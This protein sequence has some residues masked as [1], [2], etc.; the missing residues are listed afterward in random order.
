METRVHAFVD[1][2]LG[3]DDATGVA[4]RIRSGEISAAEAIEA[5]IA[6][7][8]R[9]E[10][11]LGAVQRDDF[12]RARAAS[13]RREGGALAGVFGG[14]PAA[15]KD[16]LTTRGRGMTLGSDAVSDHPRSID[17]D[18]AKQLY[19]TGMIPVATSTMPPFGWTASTERPG[20]RVTRNPW[21]LERSAG[22]S[23]G[24]SA[25]LVAAGA[26]PIAHGNDG[27][28]SIRIPAAA[29]GLVGLKP[30]RGR[31]LGDPR[32]DG[33][34]VAIV[35]GGVLT[36]SVRDTAA[37]HAALEE[38]YRNPKLQP[39]GEV[40]GAGARRLR[41][42]V[43]IDSPLG[44]PSDGPTRAALEASADL[45]D[46]LGHQVE[47]HD[48]PTPRSF[49]TDFEDYWAFLAFMVH[50]TG[51]KRMGEGFDASR[52]DPLTLGLS[53]QAARR[54]HRMPLAIARL[55]ASG[56]AYERS[57][58][59]LDVVMS[60]VVAHTTP[61]IGYLGADLP[62]E[63]HL[64]RLRAYACFTPLHN[65]AGAPAI[66]LPLGE[67]PEGMPIGVMFAARRGA[68]RILLELAYELEAAAPF[69]R[70]DP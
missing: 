50:R 14:V 31:H 16:N 6:R 54:L 23:S 5:A 58:G 67:S 40:K 56:R 42:G 12:E 68:E 48:S 37:L 43:V 66:S 61:Q 8:E 27:G 32:T 7:I 55:R 1:D 52:L 49:K 9:V 34:P 22:G 39:I 18:Y 24:G 64:E 59:A 13:K 41:V 10:P 36:R 28:G 38:T 11:Q 35:S 4:E 20:D 47:P 19:A 25:A 60:P 17:G 3:R 2:A 26:V 57:L 62:Y 70:I 33:L 69:A 51:P 45:L 21:D 46:S 30:T 44:P 29:C 63:T 53:A 65:A 15:L